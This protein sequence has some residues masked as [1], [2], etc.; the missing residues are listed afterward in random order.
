MILLKRSSSMQESSS[1]ISSLSMSISTRPVIAGRHLLRPTLSSGDSE[2]GEQSPDDIVVVKVVPLP[3][4][5][6]HLFLV[7][8]VVN[9]VT[10]TTT[11][12]VEA[13]QRKRRN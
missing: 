13:R 2:E 6:L 9:V 4:S 3:L 11:E 5:S 8:P 1:W 12:T 7:L 10:P